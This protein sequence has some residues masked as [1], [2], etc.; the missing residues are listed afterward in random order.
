MDSLELHSW[1]LRKLDP[2][3]SKTFDRQGRLMN[4]AAGSE[5]HDQFFL[6]TG[7]NQGLGMASELLLQL[8][9][10]LEAEEQLAIGRP[11]VR[12]NPSKSACRAPEPA[13][14]K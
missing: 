7:I 4:H 5:E 9:A 13:S 11:A 1:I 12:P 10:E 8:V 14:T 6:V 3:K 2:L